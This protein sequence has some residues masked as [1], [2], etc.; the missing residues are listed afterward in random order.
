MNF[1]GKCSIK[2]KQG[3][4]N[5]VE[6]LL[7][8]QLISGS[9]WPKFSKQL[10]AIYCNKNLYSMAT[11]IKWPQAASCCPKGDSVLCHTSIQQ[12]VVSSP[13]VAA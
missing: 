2:L 9:P 12:P 4:Q 10:S 13:R 11:S 5:T 8:G 7:S 6:P 1:E 3:N